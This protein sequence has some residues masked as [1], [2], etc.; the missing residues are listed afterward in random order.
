MW[1][2]LPVNLNEIKQ[3]EVIRG[4]A[5]AVWGANAFHGV[6]NVISKSPREIQG[7]SVTVGLGTI[8]SLGQRR[9]RRQ[10]LS[11]LLQRHA[12]AGDQRSLGVQAVG[13]RIFAGRAAAADRADSRLSAAGHALSSL[14]EHRYDAAEARWPDRLR[15]RG[16]PETVVLRR[17][18]RH[19]RHHAHRHRALR[20]QPGL[21]DGLCEGQFQPQGPCARASSR[22]SSTATPPTC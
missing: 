16:R 8:E 18:R 21:D 5:S 13:R 9:R 15:L 14:Q 3:I 12:R 7:T 4:P 11:G 17:R 19:R 6:V 2:F 20:H 10:R 22:M 1:D